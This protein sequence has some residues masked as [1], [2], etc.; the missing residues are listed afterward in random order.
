MR[1]INLSSWLLIT[2]LFYSTSLFA[3]ETFPV[4][5]VHDKND[6]VIAFTNATIV[7]DPNTKISNGTLVIKNNKII[8][9][10]QSVSI[11]KGAVSYDLKGKYI[12]PSFIDMFTSYG[13]SSKLNTTQSHKPQYERSKNGVGGWNDAF[14]PE[15]NTIAQF[16]PDAKKAKEYKELGFGVV[17]TH[18]PD[19]IARGA[20]SVVN[21][22]EGRT[23]N[24]VLKK[25]G[26]AFY[27]FEKGS[28]KQ[29]YPS[30]LMGAIALIR[31]NWYD[32]TW[33][34]NQEEKT[35]EDESL[36][37]LSKQAQMPM[38][39]E[40]KGYQSV[41]R[42]VKIGKEFGHQYI[43]KGS[44]D[45]YKRLDLILQ[46]GAP[47]VLP[48]EFPKAFDVEDP[49]DAMYVSTSAMKHW[50][51]APSNPA[52]LAN[53]GATIAFTLDGLKKKKDLMK[54]IRKAMQY[55]LSETQALAALTSVPAQLLKLDQEIG[56]ISTGKRANFLI[57]SGPIF[58][59]KTILHEN[60][61]DGKVHVISSKDF[62]PLIGKYNLNIDGNLFELTVEKKEGKSKAKVTR[63]GKSYDVALTQEG[64]LVTIVAT[65]DLSPFKAPFRLSGKINF[66]GK[67]WDGKAQDIDG[68]WYD[69]S[70]VR[71]EQKSSNSTNK[72]DAIVLGEVLYPN[73]GYGRKEIP[74]SQNYFIDNIAIWT[75]DSAG[76][77]TGDVIV[78]HGKIAAVGRQLENE[79][80]FE[81]I[82]GKGKHLTPGIVD[83][84]SHIAIDRGVNEGTQSSSAEVRIG[85]VIDA[86]DINVYRQ[87]AGGVTT[88]QL[89]HGSAN[90]IG[91]QSALVK[92]KWGYDAEAMKIAGAP[93]FIKFA[94]GENVKQS[95]WGDQEKIRF[96]QTRMG[97][98][99]VYYDA[100]I[101]AKEYKSAWSAFETEES[102]FKIPFFSKASEVIMPRKDLEMEA[103]VEILDK[104]RFITCHSYVQSEI[105]ML[106]HVGDSMGFQVNTFTH[107]LEGYKVADKMKAHGAAGSTFSDW[108]AYKFE[109]NDAIPYN[110]AVLNRMGIMTSIN[111]DDAEMG[112]RLNHEA[113]K[114]M[115]Y[116]G[117]SAED[118][119]KMITINPAKTLHLDDRIGSVS[120][121][122][123]ADLVI[124]NVHPLSVYAKPEL[125]MIEG[126]VFYAADKDQE[127]KAANKTER[128]RL[129]KKM[130]AAKKKGEP[131]QKVKHEKHRHY[132]CDT[133][134]ENYE[135]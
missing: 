84:H 89:L 121:G 76:R 66:A 30:S 127:L 32:A 109:V 49:F 56:S 43:I 6:K 130:L 125:T 73:N 57:T 77:F 104:K 1:I 68:K 96:P 27:S 117:V 85:D 100:F 72:E 12:Y 8:A 132:H 74:I 45:E 44:G 110:A 63:D 99:Q 28:S 116:G 38:I 112:R 16:K 25:E 23:N 120:V 119:L 97:V 36:E 33:Y 115:K 105:N 78:K 26:A 90:P 87:L 69:W 106:M 65:K 35:Y 126:T 4:N 135:Y 54:Q 42:A 51:L 122:K 11:S 118:A 79:E 92:L 52:R 88:A 67:I 101:R 31:Q 61:I 62:P 91:G 2:I 9:V 39:F 82:N 70:A 124:W 128:A 83:E 5:G 22:N 50:E 41:L 129:L 133:I 37:A 55:G 15:L 75:C 46:S 114:T 21:L 134:D 47:M 19:G 81:V 34:Y 17:V 113:A 131:T 53:A 95:N 14:H 3:Q 123:D 60:W 24:I 48:L 7:T 10:G 20:G 94:L 102:K 98:E 108:W 64:G 13:V 93:G 29:K 59:K 18:I 86:N 111:S 80:N 40:V 58:D 71:Q 107:I 103:L